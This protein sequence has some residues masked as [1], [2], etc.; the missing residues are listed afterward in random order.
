MRCWTLN[1]YVGGWVGGW[2]GD[3]P[4]LPAVRL[5]HVFAHELHEFLR[6]IPVRPGVL[7]TF[8]SSVGV[9]VGGWVGGWVAASSLL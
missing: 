2:V 1:R 7:S 5:L 6:P 9:K 4:Y 8:F 3:L